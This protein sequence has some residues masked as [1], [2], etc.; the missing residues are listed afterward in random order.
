MT[1]PFRSTAVP[2]LA[3]FGILSAFARVP[4]ALSVA[5]TPLIL[6]AT[7]YGMTREEPAAAP[8][9]AA[10]APIEAAAFRYSRAIPPGKP[11]LAA[12]VLDAAALAHSSL[13]D[14]RIAGADGRQ[15]PY[16]LER[17]DEPLTL[18]LPPLEKAPEAFPVARGKSAGSRSSY[19]V[20]LPFDSL[21]ASSLI[22]ATPARVFR[23]RVRLFLEQGSAE[24][25]GPWETQLAEADWTHADP[26]TP[27]PDLVLSL[28][29]L[30][31]ARALLTVEEGDNSPLV[32]SPPRIELPAYRMIFFREAGSSLTLLYGRKGLGPPNYDLALLK[33]GVIGAAAEEISPGP[34]IPAAAGEGGVA[35]M[36]TML[37]WIVLAVAVVVILALIARLIGKGTAA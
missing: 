31:A 28:P 10:G 2:A 9:Q 29:T 23:R 24:R 32:F 13:S 30:K 36:Q 20:D 21:P 18:V 26:E 19:Y 15:I 27:A 35:R 12:L 37:F 17:L 14:L 22:L 5:V 34:E 6:A 7:G 25:A 16:L 8:P 1:R 4:A 11:G 3:F 33:A